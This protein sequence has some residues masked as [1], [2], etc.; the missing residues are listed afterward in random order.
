MSL[1]DAHV[2]GVRVDWG[3]L[4]VGRGA[5]RVA[6]P[7]YAFQRRRYWLASGAGAGDASALGQSPAGH[8]LLGAAV[9]LAGDRE[10]LVFTGRLSLTG[11]S[12]L[13][14]HAVMGTVLLPGAGFVELALAA[15][16]RV[17]AQEVEELTLH[18]PLLLSEQGAYQVQLV[19]SEPDE[20]G[21]RSIEIYSRAEASS[22]ELEVSEWMLHASGVLAGQQGSL[23]GF[24]GLT[25]GWPPSGAEQLDVGEFYERVAEAGY[26]YGPSFQGLRQAWRSGQEVFVEVALPEEQEG[27]AQGFCVHPALFDAALHGLALGAPEGEQAQVPFSF[28]GVR[29]YA[30]G[31]SEL[32]VHLSMQEG[33]PGLVAVDSAG[34]PVFSVERIQLRA[35]DHAALRAKAPRVHDALFELDWVPLA[36]GEAG[37]GRAVLVGEGGVGRAVLLG[38]AEELDGAGIELER[39]LDLDALQ[40]AL[41][42]G[43]PAP[44]VVLVSAQTL[45]EPAVSEPAGGESAGGEPAGGDGELAGAVHR[46]TVCVLGLLQGFL[47]VEGLGEA[48]LVLITRGALAVRGEAPDLLQAALPGLLRSACVEHPGR[49]SLIDVDASEASVGC[50]GGCV[51]E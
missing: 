49:L 31:A 8:P 45:A 29:L 10:G 24:E 27:Q 26:E 22:D 21:G 7:T 4:F 32:R 42:R 15:A 5:R 2:H 47:A 46:L 13:A 37:V 35:I 44:E 48:R 20:A 23:P 18:A 6:L 12:W 9:E 11:H 25:E 17:G 28:S 50:S 43:E 33:A 30:R 16:E 38:S 3:A 19:L 40:A 41:E 34:D 1:A 51:G 14:D 36:V 39:H